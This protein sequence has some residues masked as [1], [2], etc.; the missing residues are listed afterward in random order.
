MDS[1]A[2]V[3]EAEDFSAISE[4][5][6]DYNAI[7]IPEK[8]DFKFQFTVEVRPEFPTPEWKG[9]ALTKPVESVSDAD[10]DAAIERVFSRYGSWEATDEP[11]ELGDRL[12]INATFSTDGKTLSVLEEERVDAW[13]N[14]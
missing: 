1:L 9:L 8:G 14:A 11:A 6:F 4:P 5:D 13:K 12:V 2:Q 10:V 7:E 3:T